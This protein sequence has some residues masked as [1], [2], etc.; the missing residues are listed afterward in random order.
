MRSHRRSL[1]AV[2]QWPDSLSSTLD[3]F[4]VN[5]CCCLL[6]STRICR[7]LIGARTLLDFERVET[8]DVEDIVTKK[9][10]KKAKL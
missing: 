6:E 10:A 1:R 4:C 3:Q 2:E 5:N 7:L 9:A 8:A